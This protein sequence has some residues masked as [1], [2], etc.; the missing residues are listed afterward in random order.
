MDTDPLETWLAQ[1]A[2][3]VAL[4]P[5]RW[6]AVDSETGTVVLS[7]ESESLFRDEVALWSLHN[8][9]RVP[10]TFHTGSLG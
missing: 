7:L 1:N 5:E 4:H 10:W 6:L 8:H 3:L 2:E 9:D